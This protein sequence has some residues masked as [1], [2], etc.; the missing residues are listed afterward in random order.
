MPF[1]NAYTSFAELTAH[2]RAGEDYLEI[3]RDRGSPIVVLAPHGGG[4]ER[5]TSEVAAAIAGDV[6]SLYCF[7]GLKRGDNDRLHITST[8]FDAPRC[9][10]L[11]EEAQIAVTVHGCRDETPLVYVGGRHAPLKQRLIARLRQ[12]GL[13]AQHDHNRAHAG[14]LPTNICNR[15]R[16]GRGVQLEISQGLREQLFAGLTRPERQMTTPRFAALVN[17]VRVVLHAHA[18]T[19]S[20]G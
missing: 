3:T 7:E 4:I 15:G 12:A 19:A 9:V 2:E 14:R 10:A 8:R 11:V 1:D 20:G 17:A 5:G 18:R 13:R 6:Y 16:A